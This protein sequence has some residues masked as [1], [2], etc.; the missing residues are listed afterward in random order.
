MSEQRVGASSY[1][2]PDSN[3]WLTPLSPG[4]RF[5]LS[6]GAQVASSGVL[7]SLGLSPPVSP[8]VTGLLSFCRAQVIYTIH[9]AS[10]HQD[11]KEGWL[12]DAVLLIHLDVLVHRCTIKIK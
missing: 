12:T 9:P 4:M 7:D 11:D 2:G 6:P 5:S 1:L 8:P 10:L 3:P